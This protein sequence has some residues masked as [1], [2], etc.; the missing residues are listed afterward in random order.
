MRF[1]KRDE[2]Y[3]STD[4]GQYHICRIFIRQQE[5]FEAWEGKRRL[6]LVKVD[7]DRRVAWQKAVAMCA[8]ESSST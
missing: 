8:K 5:F 7:Q 3:S 2:Y 4:D 1:L 6:G